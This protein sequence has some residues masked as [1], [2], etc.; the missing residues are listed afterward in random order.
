MEKL[1]S[2][3]LFE[4]YL[5]WVRKQGEARSTA[6]FAEALGVSRQTINKL[7]QK[8]TNTIP[9][10]K[11]IYALSKVTGDDIFEFLKIDKA[12]TDIKII[13]TTWKKIPKETQ[14]KIISIIEP[15]MTL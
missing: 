15:Y 9:R 13:K 11:T 2:E 14:N 1:F 3:F 6:E 5:D 7:M 10:M 4:T 8:G 12:Q